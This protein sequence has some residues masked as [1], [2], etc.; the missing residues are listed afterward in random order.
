SASDARRFRKEPSVVDVSTDWVRIN[1]NRFGNAAALRNVETDERY[2][3]AELDVRVG[4]LAGVLAALGVGP[5]DR[6]LLLAEGDTRTFELQFACM[7]I[8]AIMVPLNW[9]LALPELVD[10]ATDAEPSVVVH[11]DVWRD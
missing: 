3:W 7:R 11:D 4:Q 8:G 2:T 1:A 5:G 9:R 10:Q 6:V